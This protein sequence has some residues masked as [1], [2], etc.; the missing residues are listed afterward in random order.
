MGKTVAETIKDLTFDHLKNNNGLL[1]GQAITAVGYVNHTVP[2][3]CPGI[4]ELSMADVAGSGIA[5]GTALAGRRPILVIR[6]QDFLILNGSML[7]NYAAKSKDMFQQPSPIFVRALAIEG[8]GAGPVHSAKLHNIFMHFPGFRVW[9][10]ITPNEYKQTWTDFLE[11]D[12][13]VISCEHRS[14]FSSR[15][16]YAN[17]IEPAADIT[18]FGISVGR[19]NIIKAAR[20]LRAEGI[21]VNLVHIVQLKPLVLQQSWLEALSRSHCGL[22]VDTGF[23]TCGA[24]QNIAYELML[25]TNKP[26]QALGLKDVSVGVS[27]DKENLTPRPEQIVTAVKNRLRNRSGPMR[28]A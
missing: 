5:V 21:T 8:H 18:L 22:V 16:E 20:T 13:P 10:P 14:S 23:E 12:D 4:I 19:T 11:H 6:F 27:G 26:V 28:S 25:K 17:E 9:A 24:G 15:D 7:I 2:K 1:L 3:N